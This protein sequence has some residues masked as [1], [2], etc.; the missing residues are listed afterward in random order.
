M[1]SSR[2]IFSGAAEAVLRGELKTDRVKVS[3]TFPPMFGVTR[4]FNS[5]SAISKEVNDARVWGGNS[6]GGSARPFCAIS[7][8]RHAVID[9]GAR[10]RRAGDRGERLLDGGRRVAQGAPRFLEATLRRGP[11]TGRDDVLERDRVIGVLVS[12]VTE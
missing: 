6:A 3:V 5:F 11:L 4:T 7:A 12:G 10:V 2:L 1:L 8:P 9:C